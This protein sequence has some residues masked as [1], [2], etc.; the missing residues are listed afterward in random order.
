MACFV[1]I[2]IL[3]A[4]YFS[5]VLGGQQCPPPTN[6]QIESLLTT[7][8][9]TFGADG[10]SGPATILQAHITAVA[11]GTRRNMYREVAIFL[12]YTTPN[13]TDDIEF[14]AHVQARCSKDATY[15]IKDVETSGIPEST[16]SVT[17]R[18][19]CRLVFG[20]SANGQPNYDPVTNC[21][22]ELV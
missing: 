14:S 3:V 19:D 5:S 18:S 9:S 15:A 13:K 4:V 21:L 1:G 20:P 17:R 12:K 2:Y 7:A 11:V 10:G 22:G 16:L 6:S 8:R